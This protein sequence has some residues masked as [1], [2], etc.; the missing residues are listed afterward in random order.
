MWI[1]AALGDLHEGEKFLMTRRH[2]SLFLDGA[3]VTTVTGSEAGLGAL[4]SDLVSVPTSTSWPG[5]RPATAGAL[6]AGL[7]MIILEYQA[8]YDRL[9]IGAL[10]EINHH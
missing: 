1:S 4:P 10:F 9:L 2:P 8:G 5:D 3:C 6:T 7:S